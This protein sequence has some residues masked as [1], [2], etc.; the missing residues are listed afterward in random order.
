[1]MS[2]KRHKEWSLIGVAKKLMAVITK[3]ESQSF[4][5]IGSAFP[6]THADECSFEVMP[7]GVRFYKGKDESIWPAPKNALPVLDKIRKARVS[8]LAREMAQEK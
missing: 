4:I 3:D 1:M 8:Q 6:K 5:D 2:R 7:D